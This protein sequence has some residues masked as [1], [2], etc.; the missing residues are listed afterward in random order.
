MYCPVDLTRRSAST[1]AVS[2]VSG[3]D[4]FISIHGVYTHV[5]AGM[6]VWPSTLFKWLLNPFHSGQEFGPRIWDRNWKSLARARLPATTW[7]A[8]T[9]RFKTDLVAFMCG[10]SGRLGPLYL[11]T[12]TSRSTC[13]A[14]S[15]FRMR[16]IVSGN[17]LLCS[18]SQVAACVRS[19][20]SARVDRKPFWLEIFAS[21]LSTTSC[22]R[23]APLCDALIS[24]LDPT[25]FYAVAADFRNLNTSS[26]EHATPNLCN[27][28]MSSFPLISV[29]S[30]TCNWHSTFMSWVV[31]MLHI[32]MIG[33]FG[34][35]FGQSLVR[36]FIIV[37]LVYSSAKFMFIL[38]WYSCLLLG[39]M[40]VS[41]FTCFTTVFIAC[42]RSS[43]WSSGIILNIHVAFSRKTSML[44]MPAAV[45]TRRF[46]PNFASIA[47]MSVL[48]TII[49]PSYIWYCWYIYDEFLILGRSADISRTSL[50]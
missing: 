17:C 25:C 13:A 42:S 46:S 3:S 41:C 37:S 5:V 19:T 31:I 18:A 22:T 39:I 35:I 15:S 24:P 27:C 11:W 33:S 40:S 1:I 21:K 4:G 16:G 45:K 44:A 48:L 8:S 12:G 26:H 7:D 28:W 47:A 36:K 43:S 34:V 30:V 6:M 2:I 38:R 29:P 50:S 23:P 14:M 49:M 9:V 32:M 20:A 10:I